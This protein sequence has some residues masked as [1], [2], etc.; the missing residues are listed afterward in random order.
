MKKNIKCLK[1]F[2]YCLL[3]SFLF[4]LVCS[5]NSFL[6]SINTWKDA[7]AFFTVGKTMIHGGVPYK[8]IFEQKGPLLYTIYALSS[9]I[10]YNSFIGVFIMEVLF[11]SIFLLFSHKSICLFL[12]AKKSYFILPIYAVSITTLKAFSH[13]GS[14]EEFILPFMMISIYYF[15][16]YLKNDNP[17]ISSKRVILMGIF[18]GCVFWI[19]YTLIGLWFGI[20]V[21]ILI[22]E[23]IN[24][25]YKELLLNCIYF[26]LGVLISS[27]PWLIYFYFNDAIK[28]LFEVYFLININA[29][30]QANISI[31]RKILRIIWRIAKN[32][33]GS[34]QMFLGVVIG[35]LS[36]LFYQDKFKK[37]YSIFYLGFTYVTSAVFI[38]MGG[39]DYHYY[40]LPLSIYILIGLILLIKNINIKRRYE[41][42][43]LIVLIISCIIFCVFASSNTKMIRNKKEDYAQYQFANI[44]N[45]KKDAIVL[46]Y[47]F[48]DGGFYLTTNN[49][50][51][52]YYFMKTNI[53]YKNYPYE[54][55]SQDE[56]VKKKI[57]DFVI[58][59]NNL[60]KKHKD[61][62]EKGYKKIASHTQNDGDKALSVYSLYER[63]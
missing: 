57:P 38:F 63:K 45:K 12:P 9:I 3:L 22:I 62:L 35:F 33:F 21:S 4:L 50:P 27:I 47:G 52:F 49:S 29:Y 5:K 6:Y 58:I 19:K 16:S 15:L 53:P 59:R 51:S 28:D 24:K 42:I 54:M 20:M 2:L 36:L 41:K 7:N 14:A 61:I 18:C 11:F 8:T 10:K 26:F 37:K 1:P 46:N 32:T 40:A 25:R 48:L 55:D 13:G 44:I 30:P 56:Y 34:M 17:S 60:G 23:F 43:S 31:I 39:T